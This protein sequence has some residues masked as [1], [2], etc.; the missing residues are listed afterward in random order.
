LERLK[1]A[2]S[3]D[4]VGIRRAAKQQCADRRT[5]VPKLNLDH[6]GG[7]VMAVARQQLLKLPIVKPPTRPC[8][9]FYDRM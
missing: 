9:P 8:R 1:E 7:V 6:I 4:R 3:E 5:G 2:G